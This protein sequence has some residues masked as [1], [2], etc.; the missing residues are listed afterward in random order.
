QPYTT[1]SNAVHIAVAEVDP[2]TGA[3]RLRRHAVV[4]DCGTIINPLAV[5]GQMHGAIAM[6]IGGAL[7]E[8]LRYDA[9]GRQ[10]ATGFKTYLM[11]RASDVP[12]IE[13]AHKVT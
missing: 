1:F 4:D 11:P 2:Q 3:V 5:A 6:G 7:S 13:F 12:P 9:A 10:L 8:Q